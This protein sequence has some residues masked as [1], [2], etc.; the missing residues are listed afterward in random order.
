[1]GLEKDVRAHGT[2]QRVVHEKW[3]KG[4][5]SHWREIRQTGR[6]E[7]G[8]LRITAGR[9]WGRDRTHITGFHASLAPAAKVASQPV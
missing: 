6:H 8:H 9:C 7:Q 3:V 5:I 2:Q 1:M 4:G